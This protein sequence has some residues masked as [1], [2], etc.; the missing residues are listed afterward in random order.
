[1]DLRT[2][3]LLEAG[4][5]WEVRGAIY[6]TTRQLIL[7][8]WAIKKVLEAREAFGG[9]LYSRLLISCSDWA[10]HIS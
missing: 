1:M 7:Q 6:I 2:E 3:S 5:G 9:N 4:E 10:N 8:A